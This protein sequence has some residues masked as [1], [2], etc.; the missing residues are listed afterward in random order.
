MA[1][2][3]MKYRIEVD[4]RIALKKFKEVHRAAEDFSDALKV[5][6]EEIEIGIR[7]VPIKEKKWYQFWK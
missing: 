4:N 3:N 7:V 2:P 1:K 6:R 5:L